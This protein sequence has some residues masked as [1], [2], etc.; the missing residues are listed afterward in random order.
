M[1]KIRA[2]YL[3]NFLAICIVSVSIYTYI[4]FNNTKSS[5]TNTYNSESISYVNEITGNI[6]KSILK[7][8][9]NE[10]INHALKNDSNK[11]DLLE[12]YLNLFITSRYKDIYVL[13]KDPLSQKYQ[14]L[15]DGSDDINEKSEFCEEY[16][17]LEKEK[18]DTLYT[19]KKSLFFSHKKLES[20]W[21]TYLKPVMQNGEV[22]AI[23]VVDFSMED[24]QIIEK[25][26]ENLNI[27]FEDAIWFFSF[28]FLTILWFSYVDVNRE[29][30]KNE[31]YKGLKRKTQELKEESVKV[32]NL[33]TT[34]EVRVEEALIQNR[35]KD[36]QLLE[37]SRL[38]QMG[39]M[40]SMI[41]HQWRQ[42]LAAI[43]ATS[44]ALELKAKLNKSNKEIIINSAQNISSYSQH[45]SNTIDDFRDFFK[46]NKEQKEIVLTDIVNSV[47]NIVKTSI[48]NQDITLL[49]E[50]NTDAKVLT[51]P[52]ELKQVVL[53]LI[54][55]AEDIL[56]EKKIEKPFIKVLTYADENNFILEVSDNAGGVPDAIMEKIFD[57]Y[58]STKHEKNGTGLGLY[59]SQTII[60]KHCD[61][62]LSVFNNTEGAVFKIAL[63][64]GDS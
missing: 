43:S 15:L 29:K 25:S 40:L 35:K 47:L 23:I 63:K 37:Q 28:I 10:N 53:N 4:E 39:E 20:L 8:I 19:S 36:Q 27:I 32:H 54:K 21:M 14:F 6:E 60:N 48:Q 22:I 17:P 26:L 42:P 49:S 30:E 9:N 58:F 5:I 31:I 24:Y 7:E 11:I 51:Y 1:I 13:E 2:S 45:L 46:P 44:A 55:N 12:S 33:N 41:A 62:K 61:G 50:F 56:L 18:F 57:P 16:E 52:N 38:A 59:M 64:R 3:F 34:L